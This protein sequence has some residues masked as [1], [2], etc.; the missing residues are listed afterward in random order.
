M[1]SEALLGSLPRF[2]ALAA[3]AL[4]LSTGAAAQQQAMI[5]LDSSEPVFATLAALNA[6]G[7]DAELSQS[8]PLRARVR[9]EIAQNVSHSAEAQAAQQRVCSFYADHAA[10]DPSRNLAQYMSLALYLTEPPRFELTTRAADLPPD[11]AYVLGFLPLLQK[12]YDAAGVHAVWQ[13]HQKDYDALIERYGEAVGKMRF[14]TDIYLK[15]ASANY[16]DRAFTVYLEPLEAPG[17]VNSRN[18]GADYFLIISPD[19][20]GEIP[21]AQVRHTYL[22]Y[23]LDPL[24][25]GRTNA[26]RRL[27]PLL[28]AVQ[29]APLDESFK[30]DVSLLVTESLIQAIE[31]RTLPGGKAA[32]A[33]RLQHMQNA[34]RQ[35][36]IL[37]H[38]FYQA[39]ENFEK[40]AQGLNAAYGD[41]LHYIL[42]DT[43]KKRAREITFSK[44][45]APEVL[46]AK[47]VNPYE[48]TLEIAESRLAAG[49]VAGARKY[50]Q[51][52]FDQKSG[53]P[54]HATFILARCAVMDGQ[55]ETAQ[56]F[57]RQTIELARDPR[58]VAWS[59]I[60][61]GRIFDMQNAR[62]EALTHYRAALSAGDP[63]PETRKAAERGIEQPY[64]PATPRQ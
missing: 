41:M 7:Y 42:V 47:R 49:D 11:A 34:M 16:V 58:M 38:Y 4:G 19:A 54:A 27:E 22:H 53:D 10:N 45:A 24:A 56:K 61:L 46:G 15:L 13:R 1:F 50:A 23:V 35:G 33:R 12:F 52:V 5:R 8:D 39:L 2:V 32:E 14:D 26:M 51:D 64:A 6:C 29:T 44:E 57:F 37:T 48:K 20:K 40:G 21:M 3:L 55:V 43:E 17:Q 63:R 18:Y 62:D 60:Y 9:G 25:L 30:Y 59:H 28:D 31:A 36:Y